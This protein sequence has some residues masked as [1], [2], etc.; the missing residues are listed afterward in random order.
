M[1]TQ[2]EIADSLTALTLVMQGVGDEVTKVAG[3]TDKS[4]QQIADLTA[5]INSGG[6][7]SPE[8]VDAL[9]AL[10]TS[11]TNVKTGLQAIDDKI[12][13]APAPPTA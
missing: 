9:A 6:N 2:K 13:D 11:V 12:P 4:L 10:T 5:A 7:A 1:A 8:V 3:E